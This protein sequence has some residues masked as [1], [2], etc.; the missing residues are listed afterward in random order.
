MK[1]LLR[2]FGPPS[3]ALVLFLS[4][5]PAHSYARSSKNRMENA[6]KEGAVNFYS[7]WNVPHGEALKKIFEKKYPFI[8]VNHY[9]AGAG[10]LVNKLDLEARSRHHEFDVLIMTDLYWQILMDK[11]LIAPYCSPLRAA[12][13]AVFK[14]K[15]C[16]WTMLNINTHVMAY[17]TELV[18]KDVRPKTLQDLLHPRW[19]GKLVMDTTDDR[20]FTETVD[21]MGEE[22][23]MAFMK[24]LAAQKPNFRRGHTLMVQLLAAG[25]FPVNVIAYGYQVEYM[26]AQGATLDWA[27]DQPVTVTGGVVSLARHAP[28]P[29]AGKLFIDFLMSK[30][31]QEAITKFNRVATRRDVPPNPPG[32]IEGLQMY[33][34]N[35]ELGK[36]LPKRVK[37]FR[38]IFGIR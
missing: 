6:K 18:P 11:G 1:A 32:Q 15:K 7:V 14:D 20:W 4:L 38:K 5:S 26:K 8:K 21:K 36:D 12:F 33:P 13:P 27:A 16:R 34:V 23:G 10:A 3:L 28:H 29:T 31:A 17:N 37:Q 22:K 19:K 30:K 25:E 9:R 35:L 2:F 24:K